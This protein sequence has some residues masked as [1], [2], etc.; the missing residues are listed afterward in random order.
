M[1]DSVELT[2]IVDDVDFQEF[3]STKFEKNEVEKDCDCDCSEEC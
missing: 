2:E 1:E 3:V